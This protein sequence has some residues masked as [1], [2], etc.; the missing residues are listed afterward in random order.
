[1]G[2]R[3]L[4]EEANQTVNR[5][6]LTVGAAVAIVPHPA[7]DAIVVLWRAGV[8]IRRIGQIYGLAPTGLS[9][10]RLLK[11]AIT[12]AIMAAGLDAAGD[13]VLEEVGRGVMASTGKRVAESTVMATRLRRLGKMTQRLC[14]PIPTRVKLRSGI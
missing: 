9:S 2:L 14:R 1:M 12:S 10:L 5:A 13:V 3:Q 11:H 4:D 6:S 7:L 8:L